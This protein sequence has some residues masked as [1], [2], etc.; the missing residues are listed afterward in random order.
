[1]IAVTGAAGFIGSTLAHRLAADGHDLV[2][3]DEALTPAKA[4]NLAG[5]DSFRYLSADRF[6]TELDALAPTTV[7]HLG[8]NSSTTETSW[9]SLLRTNVNYTRTLWEWCAA[10]RVPLVYASSAA[11]YGS[12]ANGFDDHT[13]P[14]DLT[15]LNLYGKSKNDFDAWA[16]AEVTAGRPAPP[17][18]AGVK[19]FNVYGPREAHKGRMA[20][21]VHHCR[22]QVLA[23][24]AVK[25][26]RSTDPAYADGGQLRDFVFVEDCVSHCL[27]LATHNHPGGVFN[28][29]SGD[30]RPFNALAEAVFAGLERPPSIEY[31]EMPAD[32]RG[33]YQN[34]TKAE[35]GK[36]R[37]VGCDV[38]ATRLED[39]VRRTVG[40]LA[41]NG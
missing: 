41:A 11:T 29:G 32:L 10:N 34:Y 3:V 30:A 4:A 17:R 31:V 40:W 15:P 25:L 18:W 37:A 23:T 6:L 13:P 28:S 38:P 1:M 12:G 35:L 22:R 7:Y 27:W 8:A 19:F 26:F 21:M 9:D 16:L 33:Q 2:L 14:A 5:L 24:G 39:G 36:L 20:S